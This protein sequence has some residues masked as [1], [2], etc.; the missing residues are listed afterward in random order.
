MRHR[1][2]FVSLCILSS[3]LAVGAKEEPPQVLVW[4]QTGSPAL[5]FSFGKFKDLGA[6]GRQRSLVTETTAQNLW[7]QKITR[8]GFALYVFDKNKVRI[9]ESYIPLNNLAPG[10][11]AKFQTHIAVS[12]VPASLEIVAEE[13]PPEFRAKTPTPPKVISITVNSVPQGASLKVD[14]NDVGTTPR[15]IHVNPGHHELEFSKE[16]FNAGKFPF[17]LGPDD[18]S[19]GSVSYELGASAHDT[20][21]LRDGSVLTCDVESMTATEVVIRMAGNLQHLDRNKVKRIGLVERDP[22]VRSVR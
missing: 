13:V 19:G 18:A 9:G 16:G 4:P 20:V 7:N 14:G 21:E 15:I 2:L 3:T 11:I 6:A 12:G 22:P 10:E 17:E 1:L 8:A 5:R